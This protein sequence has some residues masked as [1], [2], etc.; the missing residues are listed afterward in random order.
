[1]VRGR[2]QGKQR[3]QGEQREQREQGEQWYIF[4]DSGARI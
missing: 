3:E 4:P 2:E 1:V